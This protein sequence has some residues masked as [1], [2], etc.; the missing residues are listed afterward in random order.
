[1]FWL[2]IVS[3]FIKILREGQTPNQIAGGFALG[4]LVGLS[5][6]FTLQGILIWLFILLINVNLSAVFLSFTLFSLIAYLMDPLFHEFGFYLLVH[7]EGLKGIWTS[8][9]NAPLAPLTRFNNT[10]VLG[11]LVGALFLFLPVFFGMKRFVIAYRSGVGAK[12][13]RWKV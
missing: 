3:R 11:S 8:L 12:I 6:N 9:Y 7:V 13:E 5:P 1:M 4:A 2:Q 10:V